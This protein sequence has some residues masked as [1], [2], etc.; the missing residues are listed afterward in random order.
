[1]NQKE[2]LRE[3]VKHGNAM[4]PIAVYR[5]LSDSR[6]PNRVDYHWHEETEILMIINGDGEIQI[7]E[8]SWYIKENDIIF[9]DSGSLHSITCKTG[10][11]FE[12]YAIIFKQEF[13]HSL[14]NDRIQQHY[15]DC[16]QSKE[17]VFEKVTHSSSSWGREIHDRILNIFSV[18]A[19]H[20]TG[21]ELMVKSDLYAV[22]Y[23]LYLH[24]QV[25]TRHHIKTQNPRIEMTKAII[26]YIENN[27]NNPISITDISQFLHVSNGY[28]C[29]FFKT[30]TNMTVIEYINYYRINKSASLLQESQ[31]EI[32]EIASLVGFNNISYFN[33]TFRHYMHITPSEYRKLPIPD[34]TP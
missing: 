9:I 11:I 4:F 7:D 19:K 2:M 10:I 15:F 1:M 22:W 24:A 18:Y 3:D 32:G 30:V 5:I 33:K 34:Y 27:Y 26:S 28:L 8:Q 23:Q 25:V 29:R 17:T 21:Y 12:Y 16:I 6:I 14:T 13:L 31:M 20:D